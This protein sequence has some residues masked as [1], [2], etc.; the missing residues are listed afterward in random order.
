MSVTGNDA[1]L[2]CGQSLWW[3]VCDRVQVCGLQVVLLVERVQTAVSDRDRLL[4]R[5]RFWVHFNFAQLPE[6]VLRT[7]FT[8]M[9]ELL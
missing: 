5:R 1:G 8:L 7:T 4:W 6:Y 2:L 3:E 9:F